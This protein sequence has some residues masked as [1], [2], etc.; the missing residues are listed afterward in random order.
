MQGKTQNNWRHLLQNADEF[1]NEI[2]IDKNGAWDKLYARLHKKDNRK[3]LSTYWVAAC[4]IFIATLSIIFFS[5]EKYKSS[6]VGIASPATYQAPTTSKKSLTITEEKKKA[7]SFGS[8]AEKNSG[9]S[10]TPKTNIIKESKLSNHD[11]NTNFP[12]E[13]I[14]EEAFTPPVSNV[15]SSAKEIVTVT[16]ARK[17]LRVVHINDLSQPAEESIANKPSTQREGF[18]IKILNIENHNPLP[19]SYASNSLIQFKPKNAS[20]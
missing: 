3:L 19:T 18:F 12:E 1:A 4:V 13:Q 20:N 5:N 9:Y 2:L 16:P 8:T 11:R 17:K 14:I 6:S 7:I 10:L 15:D